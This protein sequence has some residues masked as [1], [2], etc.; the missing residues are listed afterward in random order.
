MGVS[1]GLPYIPRQS[2]RWGLSEANVQMVNAVVADITDEEHRG[3]AM[4]LVGA[5]FSVAFTFGPALGVA[6]S[7]I[8]MVAEN[9][10]IVAAIVSFALISIETVYLWACLPETHPR[11]TTLQMEGESTST[12]NKDALGKKKK[13]GAVLPLSAP[14]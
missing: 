6:L 1:Y 3:S 14:I 2:Y 5:C 12:E 8:N 13:K 10:F 11:L 4:A 9:P 7:S